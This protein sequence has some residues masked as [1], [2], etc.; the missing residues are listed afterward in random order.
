MIFQFFTNYDANHDGF[1]DKQEAENMLNELYART[2]DQKH[3][4][5]KK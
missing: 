4:V 2:K 1:L 3:L 5:T